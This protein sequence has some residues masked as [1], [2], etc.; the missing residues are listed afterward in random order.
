MR[1]AYLA[2]PGVVGVGDFD[3]PVA[4]PGEVLVRMHHASICGSDTHV[5]FDGFHR[6]ERLGLPGYPGHE[7]VG[8]V[9]ESHVPGVEPGDHVLTVPPGWLGACFAERQVVA[10]EHLVVLPPDQPLLR[11]LMAQQLGTTLFAMKRF[12]RP[13]GTTAAVIG[14]GSAGSYFVQHLRRLGYEHVVVADLDAERLATAGRLGAT[15]LVHAPD[16]SLVDVVADLTDGEG[17]ALVVEAA[18]YDRC[19]AD[20]I[21][22]VRRSGTVGFFGYPE[23]YGDAPYPAFL[24]F[25]RNVSIEWINGAQ[26][27]P[28]LASFRE[29]VAAIADGT[30]DVDHCLGRQLDLEDAAEAL[31]LARDRGR[32]A[33]KVG[34]D[35]PA[36]RA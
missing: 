34:L 29:A 5:V 21:Q 12:G 16:E 7:G 9:E 26:L 22:A 24:A 30:V 15:H 23:R 28:G 32:G 10:G 4:G 6:P 33:T 2:A 31:A 35:L 11:M 27:E 3:D 14:A 19:R 13:E 8:V 17:A 20:A 18:G 1:A 25:R 36:S